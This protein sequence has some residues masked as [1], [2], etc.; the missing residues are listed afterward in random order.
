MAPAD[1]QVLV[2]QAVLIN[3]TRGLLLLLAVVVL[4]VAVQVDVE[5][6]VKLQPDKAVVVL[7]YT[8]KDQAVLADKAQAVQEVLTVI[9][10]R[11]VCMAE[12]EVQALLVFLELRVVLELYG[13]IQIQL[14]HSLQQM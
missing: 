3:S 13:E 1:I 5:P 7:V 6:E 10:L 4:E 11:L 8:A 9:L 2:V 12:A 14:E